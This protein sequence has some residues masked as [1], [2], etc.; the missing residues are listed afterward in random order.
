MSYC[1]TPAEARAIAALIDSIARDQ[2]ISEYRDYA[3]ESRACGYEPETLAE[4][5]GEAP[6]GKAAASTR[7]ATIPSDELDLY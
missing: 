7:L 6:S 2:R 3:T 4:Y 1:H 5:L